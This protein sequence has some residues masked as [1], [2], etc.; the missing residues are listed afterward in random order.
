MSDGIL[1][2]LD[3]PPPPIT[4]VDVGAMDIGA[5]PYAALLELPGTRVI[6]FE[7]NPEECAK[8]NEKQLTSHRYL[9]YFVGDGRRRTFHWCSWAATSSLYPPN[10]KLLERFSD[11]AELVRV[12][13]TSEVE[14]TR[15]DDIPEIG[16]ADFIKIDVQGAT[17]D[18]LQG[19]RQTVKNA[20]V[21]QC[22]VEFVPLYTGEPL[23]A[24]VDQEM[25]SQGYLFHQF[26]ALATRTFAPLRRKP[27]A[28]PHGQVL[29]TDAIYFRSFLEL[30]QLEPDQ[31]LKLA[32]VA[33]RVYRSRDLALFALQHHDAKTGG[34][35]WDRYSTLLTGTV[36][37]KPP[38]P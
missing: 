30:A 38:L 26:S 23:F 25:R 1:S 36:K 17:L 14:T 33:E 18:V 11:L 37:A 15:L 32:I 3:G 29:W 4:I 12:A 35:L 27:D 19:G 24:E 2:L 28:P 9:P 6:G 20:V 31:L 13:S 7:P 21:V 8:L 5:T 10:T 16:G 34:S 22:E